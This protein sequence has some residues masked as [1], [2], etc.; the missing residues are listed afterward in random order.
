MKNIFFTSFILVILFLTACIEK[1]DK[2]LSDEAQLENLAYNNGS[3]EYPHPWESD[4]GWGGGF[5]VWTIIDGIRY[6]YHWKDGLAFTGGKQHYIDSCGWRQATINFGE[7]KEFNKVIIWHQAS[8]HG[9]SVYLKYKIQYYNDANNEWL[10][11]VEHNNREL[12]F[13]YFRDDFLYLRLFLQKGEGSWWKSWNVPLEDTFKTVK[14]SKVR[15]KLWNCNIK[16]G[17]ITEF[18][19]YKN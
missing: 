16:H 17:W 6:A 1:P 4:I 12:Y 8:C 5:Y 13:A 3:K 11:A 2:I 14:A 7:P 9:C 19:V 15:F 18:E 10:T